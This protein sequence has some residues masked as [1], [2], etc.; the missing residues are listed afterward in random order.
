MEQ[1]RV[2]ADIPRSARDR[3]KRQADFLG[4]KFSAFI[5]KVLEEQSDKKLAKDA[6]AYPDLDK[7]NARR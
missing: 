6:E 2:T 1:S 3:L 5:A 4:M 7:L